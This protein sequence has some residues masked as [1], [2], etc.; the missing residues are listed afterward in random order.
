MSSSCSGGGAGQAWQR[1][2]RLRH[3]PQRERLHCPAW[4]V[5]LALRALQPCAA[6]GA[7]HATIGRRAAAA[8]AA[9]QCST[10]ALLRRPRRCAAT[11]QGLER[12]PAHGPGAAACIAAAC[13]SRRSCCCS[14][15]CRA[16]LAAGRGRRRPACHVLQAPPRP[17]AASRAAFHCRGA[18]AVPREACLPPQP[19]PMA[20]RHAPRTCC[21][22][23][24]AQPSP[25]AAN[26]LACSPKEGAG[27]GRG[28]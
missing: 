25:G 1:W 8:G 16:A 21:A 20:H 24:G 11:P 17:V 9:A 14:C 3:T 7:V 12:S 15:R 26:Q 10:H 4:L 5:P 23:G 19:R 13:C 6:A 2:A 22:S 18:A 27:R 28:A